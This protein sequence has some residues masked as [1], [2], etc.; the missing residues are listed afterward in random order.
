MGDEASII[1]QSREPVAL[2]DQLGC[3]VSPLSLEVGTLR[4]EGLWEGSDLT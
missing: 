4:R 3:T 1:K 2:D